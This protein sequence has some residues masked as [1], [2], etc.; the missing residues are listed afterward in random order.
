[1]SGSRSIGSLEYENRPNTTTA[2]KQ[3]AVK[4]GLLTDPSYR[5]MIYFQNLISNFNF[6]TVRQL[7]LSCNHNLRTVRHPRYKFVA[8]A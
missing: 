6:H 7:G 1:M 3:S 8:I 4:I 2:T 5:L